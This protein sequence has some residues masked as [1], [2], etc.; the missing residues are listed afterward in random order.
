MKKVIIP[1]IFIFV[2]AVTGFAQKNLFGIGWEINFPNNTDYLNKTSY[3][4]G[5]I[6]YR[7]FIKKNFS[8]GIAMNWATYEEHLPRQ[9]F[10]KPD[11]NSAVTGDFV[12]QAY[13]LPITAT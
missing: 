9:T 8:A 4:G 11:G 3:A 10:Q 7:H 2:F 13:Q 12:A 1:S 5:K 6:E